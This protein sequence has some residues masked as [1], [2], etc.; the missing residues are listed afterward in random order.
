VEATSAWL[1]DGENAARHD[2]AVVREGEGLAILYADG[3]RSVV[4][5]AKLFHAQSR[6]ATEVYGHSD[7]A[8]WRLG[9]AAP[10]PEALAPILPARRR[11]GRWID[12]IGLIPAVILFGALSIAAILAAGRFPGWAAPYLPQSVEREFGDVMIAPLQGGFCMGPGGQEA[13]DKLVGLLAPDA[14][15]L[16]VRVHQDDLVN[17]AALP[18]R[19]IVIF[20]GLLEISE[21]PE[22]VAG[23]LAHEIAH[24]EERH[25]AESLIRSFT[26]GVFVSMIG[27]NTGA[28]IETLLAAGYSRG[29]ER[30]A[31]EGAI[32]RLRRA[33]VSP[34][35]AAEFFAWVAEQE[36]ELGAVS[37]GLSYISTHP[38]PAGRERMFRA[39]AADQ[40]GFRPALSADEWD[41]L[42]NICR[43]DPG[44]Q[45]RGSY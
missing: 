27:G 23:I 8:G 15:G 3:D 30:E 29:A 24:I 26:F 16:D 7:A 41:S 44:L 34:L 4:P 28:G 6:E 42:R 40:T 37:Q 39:A 22:E 13:L 36:E 35:G 17:A 19:R 43:S 14:E 9:L 5:A 11:Y 45:Q 2:V 32:E 1:Y 25:V 33:N 18:G 20:H 10:L 12:R 21:E 31:D 38:G